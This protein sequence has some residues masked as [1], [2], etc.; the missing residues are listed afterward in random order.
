MAAGEMDRDQA[1]SAQR[2]RRA[3]DVIDG[4][5]L[6]LAISD[7]AKRLL[8]RELEALYEAAIFPI[9]APSASENPF[10]R[11]RHG[12]ES[13]SGAGFHVDANNEGRG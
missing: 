12:G 10:S 9:T 11:P 2:I 8:Q 6:S 7:S 3:H 13:V 4:C 1:A 5:I